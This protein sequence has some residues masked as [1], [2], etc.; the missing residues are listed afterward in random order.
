MKDLL[1]EPSALLVR[2]ALKE[3]PIAWEDS[4][5]ETV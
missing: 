5:A 2:R 1:L 4:D 3:H